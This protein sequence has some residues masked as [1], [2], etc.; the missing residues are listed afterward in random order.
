MKNC[1]PRNTRTTR[2]QLVGSISCILCI[3]W[4]ASHAAVSPHPNIMWTG[5]GEFDSYDIEIA[6][7]AEFVNV[8]DK[9]TIEN[10]SRYVPAKALA[11]GT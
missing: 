9:D 10:I 6:S 1:K 8:V 5:G 3:S 7:D 4:S 2:K 11:A